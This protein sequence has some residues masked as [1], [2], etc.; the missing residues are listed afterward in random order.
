M[1]CY[2]CGGQIPAGSKF[3]PVCGAKQGGVMCKSCGK[4]IDA[5]VKFCPE[6][7]AQQ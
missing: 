3:C 2:N 5:G 4:N 6:C 7:G 1:Q